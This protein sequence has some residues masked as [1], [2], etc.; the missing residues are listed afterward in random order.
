MKKGAILLTLMIGLLYSCDSIEDKALKG[1]LNAQLRLAYCYE[2]GDSIGVQDIE[3]ARFYHELAGKQGH[4]FSQKWLI[5]YYDSKDDAKNIFVWHEIAANFGAKEEQHFLGD[6]YKWG[7]QPVEADTLKAIEWYQKAA[8]QNDTLALYKMGELWFY[9]NTTKGL[10]I[11]TKAAELKQSDACCFLGKYYSDKNDS[12]KALYWYE[13]QFEAGDPYGYYHIAKYLLAKE[14]TLTQA[15][16]IKALNYYEISY[17]YFK[18]K[19]DTYGALSLAE[20][21]AEMYELLNKHNNNYYLL[22]LAEWALKANDYQK[23]GKIYME[24]HEWLEA[25]KCYY[26]WK[27]KKMLENLRRQCTIN[28]R[29]YNKTVDEWWGYHYYELRNHKHYV[30]T[31]QV[32]LGVE[33]TKKINLTLRVSIIDS[34]MCSCPRF[35]YTNK[36]G[37]FTS[38][39]VNINM[40]K[41]KSG[42]EQGFFSSTNYE[43]FDVELLDEYIS[44]FKAF[45]SGTDQK[46][47]INNGKENLRRALSDREINNMRL[48]ME[49]YEMVLISAS[50]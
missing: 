45:L 12:E 27:D 38:F 4:L 30:S 5:N 33:K 11:I 18:S 1:D 49:A 48:M 42:S 19:G 47:E 14:K 6:Y 10:D 41:I 9:K 7:W 50:K 24:A 46:I 22:D 26:Q 17:S 44:D 36:N 28:L 13:K 16:I 39:D 35:Y 34:Q 31:N 43:Y 3:K 29:N 25:Y 23:A 21:V 20:N 15:T 2:T 32:S 37:L 8:N 40:D